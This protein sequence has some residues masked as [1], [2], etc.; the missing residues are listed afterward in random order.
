MLDLFNRG[1]VSGMFSKAGRVTYE[2]HD[3]LQNKDAIMDDLLGKKRI[4]KIPNVKSANEKNM[5]SEAKHKD[6]DLKPLDKSFEDLQAESKAK[7][8]SKLSKISMYKQP[9]AFQT[10]HYYQKEEFNAPPVGMYNPRFESILPKVPSMKIKKRRKV[11]RPLNW[12]PTKNYAEEKQPRRNNSQFTSLPNLLQEEPPMFHDSFITAPKPDNKMHQN[13]N[14]MDSM[15][16]NKIQG[17]PIPIEEQGMDGEFEADDIAQDFQNEFVQD[18]SQSKIDYAQDINYFENSSVINDA[19]GYYSFHK[20]TGRGSCHKNYMSIQPKPHDN[21]FMTYQKTSPKVKYVM[22]FADTIGREPVVIKKQVKPSQM[23]NINYG[24]T[25]KS[26]KSLPTF[27]KLMGRKP[28]MKPNYCKNVQELLINEYDVIY[29]KQKHPTFA[30]SS[31]R[32]IKNMFLLK[33]K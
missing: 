32:N 23:Y 8:K 3:A 12:S 28:F 9:F 33:S 15:D 17:G 10:S 7:N 24:Q 29:P 19:K 25:M 30:K 11:K 14:Y 26:S 21:R 5:F 27:N 4:K 22:P 13:N 31:G 18:T 1:D 16:S 6:H 20:M 2:Q